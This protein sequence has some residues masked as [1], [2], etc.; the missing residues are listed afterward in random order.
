MVANVAAFHLRP[1]Y[2]GLGPEPAWLQAIRHDPIQSPCWRQ[3]FA[4]GGNSWARIGD[5][6]ALWLAEKSWS[7]GHSDYYYGCLLSFNSFH[8]INITKA[9]GYSKHNPSELQ[10]FCL[11]WVRLPYCPH[12]TFSATLICP[13][14][15]KSAMKIYIWSKR[16]TQGVF[17]PPNFNRTASCIRSF[18]APGCSNG[19]RDRSLHSAL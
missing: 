13:T 19:S 2:C 15:P 4:S 10:V 3:Q 18:H 9:K 14:D 17:E 12:Q 16:R 8:I 5:H 7:L 6:V 1:V 11:S